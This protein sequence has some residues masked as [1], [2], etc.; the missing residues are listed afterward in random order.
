MHYDVLILGGGPAGTAAAR[1]LAQA[2]R[3]TAVLEPL[4]MGGTCLNRG[5]IPTKMLLGAVAPLELLHAQE[6][7]RVLKGNIDLDFAALRAR[8]S[9]FLKGSSQAVAKSLAALGVDILP[10]TGRLL[11]QGRVLLR[12][13]EGETELEADDIILACG[14]SNASFPGLSPD[15]D[16]VLDSTGLLETETV[17]ESLIVVGAGAIGL[18]LGHFFNAAGSRVTVVEAAPHIAPLEDRDIAEEL[19][20]LLKKA[21]IAC[22]EGRPAASLVT[23]DGQAELTLADGTVLTA[24]RALV[25]VGRRPN[26]EG[27][28][29]EEASCRLSRRGYVETDDHLE[30]APHVY[31]VG[32]IN[33][34]VLLAHAAEHQARYAAARILGQAPDPYVQ[35]PVPSCYY[36]LE[37]MRVGETA[38][39][40]LAQGRSGVT[41]SRVPMTLNPIAQAAGAAQGFVKAVWEGDR[42][43]GLAALGHGVSHLV[44]AAQMLI[45]D[46]YTPE[47]LSGLML[48]HPTLDEIL[49][50][51]ILAP[52]SPA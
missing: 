50:A 46:G 11:G 25:A 17:P 32:D 18:E 6:R 1:I 7:Q 15:G 39:G 33:G 24:A 12:T 4:Q 29:C 19:R 34:R 20:K 31:A 49:A 16:C 37:I 28:G 42:L 51:A 36:G 9:R 30:A 10:G 40:L 38:A 41:V 44:T 13:A 48:A 23:K 3:K 5:C 2:G 27:L 21:G 47:R 8:I 52:R 43:A 14:S 35:G 22:F 45:L 26:T